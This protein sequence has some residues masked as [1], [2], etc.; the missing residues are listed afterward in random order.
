MPV[1]QQQFPKT[2]PQCLLLSR[3]RYVTL[4]C[5]VLCAGMGGRLMQRILEEGREKLASVGE[6]ILQPQSELRAFRA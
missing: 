4:P 5:R 6:L 2:I 3:N 1:G